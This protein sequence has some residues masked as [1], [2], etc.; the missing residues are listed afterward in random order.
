MDSLINALREY[1]DFLVVGAIGLLILSLPFAIHRPLS[2]GW[3][4]VIDHR[5]PGEEGEEVYR[6]NKFIRVRFAS[7]FIR[8]GF[9]SG[10]LFAILYF[11]GYMLNGFGHQ[12]LHT[13]HLR[14]I[15]ESSQASAQKFD[16]VGLN[17]DRKSVV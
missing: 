3:H 11:S 9:A 4:L 7:K 1:I 5:F 17:T 12:L 13:V 8:V 6:V 15:Y 14:I 16:P 2:R 10:T